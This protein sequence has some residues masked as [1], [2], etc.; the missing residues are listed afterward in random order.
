MKGADWGARA[1]MKG[2]GWGAR[3]KRRLKQAARQIRL[4]S[5]ISLGIIENPALG[6]AQGGSDVSNS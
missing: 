3:V 1:K 5:P 4:D 2:A 6:Q